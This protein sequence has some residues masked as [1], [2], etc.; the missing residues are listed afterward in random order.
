MPKDPTSREAGI[1]TLRAIAILMVVIYHAT[2]NPP[3][4][5]SVL[6]TEYIMVIIYI[7]LEIF[8]ALAGYFYARR[9]VERATL[10]PSIQLKARRLLLPLFSM[11]TV[12]LVMRL[13][14]PGANKVPSAG[15]FVQ[16]YIFRF[17]HLWY[18]Q[19]LF[20]IF[21]VI[22]FIDAFELL[23]SWQ[24]L[25]ALIL[26][27]FLM[28]LV[29]PLNKFFGYAGLVQLMP[30]FLVGYG[31]RRWP[32]LLEMPR[33]I[34]LAWL[35][36]I[37]GMGLEQLDY[38]EVLPLSDLIAGKYGVLNLFA[39]SA[40]C[41]LAIRYR[42]EIPGLNFIGLFSF[43]IYIFHTIGM[44]VAN[45]VAALTPWE[46]SFGGLALLKVLLG[47]FFPIAFHLS[48]RRSAILSCLFLGDA[49]KW[50]APLENKLQA[51]PE[52]P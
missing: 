44:A 37:V 1:N 10:A 11:T 22:S 18:L 4:G 47:V 9:R 34:L 2:I 45:R 25:L 3:P 46:E 29:V 50:R 39:G 7:P 42:R 19:A 43:S 52:K 13:I 35:A 23:K 27:W 12:L 24:G 41:V 16:A 5:S 48:I 32:E 33:F 21:V 15:D 17:E 26:G 36:F 14:I 49:W 38:R 30:F 6:Y 40:F 28:S 8:T 31:L 20:L 51:E